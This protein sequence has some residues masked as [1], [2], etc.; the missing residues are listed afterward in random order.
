MVVFVAGSAAVTLLPAVL[1]VAGHKINALSIEKLFFWQRR[2]SNKNKPEF[3]FWSWLAHLVM[4]RPFSFF[5]VVL[6]ILLV[7]GIPF[8]SVRFS[9]P[10]ESILPQSVQSR[11]AYDLVRQ[12][13][14]ESE[15][16]PIILAITTPNGDI[17]SP[18]NIYYLYQ[19]THEIQQD[20]AVARVDSIVTVEP[21]LSI[22][23]YQTI[24]QLKDKMGSPYLSTLLKQYA[25]G[26]T[27]LISIV[28]KNP[29]LDPQSDA[30][31]NKIRNT[32]L[33]NGLKMLIGG[34]T[35]G[36]QD[37]VKGIYGNFPLAVTLIVISTYIVLLILLRSVVLPLKALLMNALS[38]TASYGAL[39]FVFQ[40]GHFSGLLNFK[41]LGF[42]EPTLPIIMFCTLFGLSMDYEVFLLSRIKEHYDQTKDNIASVAIGLQRSGKIITSAALIVVAVSLSFVAADIVLVKALG[43]GLAVAVFLDATLVRALLVPSTMRLL[44]SWNWYAPKWLLRLLPEAKLES[45]TV[46]ILR[47]EAQDFIENAVAAGSEPKN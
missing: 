12:Y 41:A 46:E 23:Q 45:E 6:V 17:L 37:T 4:K 31:V 33:P 13:F 26:D 10:N 15:T 21:R 35:A 9:S 27:T 3:H 29:P 30:L 1:S 44:G 2:A 18:D 11:Q 36:V 16:S 22:E 19:Y 25:G 32:P 39:V 8:L 40:E 42:I 34:E 7:V 28:P 20:P 43:I 5:I 14:S 47:Q 38:I 24:Y